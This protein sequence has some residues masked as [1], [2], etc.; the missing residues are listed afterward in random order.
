M[1]ND[2]RRT[3]PAAAGPSL[4]ALTAAALALPGLAQAQVETDLLYSRYEEVDL[5]GSREANGQD[6]ER[7]EIDTYL[8]RLA[9]PLG[10]Q[11]FVA[12]VTY[13]TL[14]GASPWY[15]QPRQPGVDDTPV[16]V[17]SGA[18]IREQ[19]T[20]VQLSWALPLA[21][22]DWGVTL[23]YSTEDDYRA[24]S[25][26]IEFEYTPQGVAHTISGGIG[27]SYDKIEPERGA[28]SPDVIAEADKDSLSAF[29]GVSWV[30]NAKTVLQTAISY[31]LHDGF[32]SDPYKRAYV[33][34]GP[35]LVADSRPGEREQF[36]VSARLRRYL[37]G[38][39]AALHADYRF[40][41][42]DWDIE[43]H[44]LELAWHQMLAESWRLTPSLRWYSQSQASFYAPYYQ[45]L[46]SDG[47]ASSDYR[48]SPYGAVA[49][50]IDLRKA[51]PG[52]WEIGGGAEWYEAD[53]SYAIDTVEVE[54]PGL[55]E[56]LI[57]NLRLGKRF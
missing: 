56:F 45:S 2:E 8:F 35:T 4:S 44:T 21:G 27:Y 51:L 10:D 28:S 34:D 41:R 22:I 53:G 49:V 11:A 20:D 39:G 18:S 12:N 40:Y 7:Y 14:S 33:A 5:P 31:G 54:N 36:T 52:D 19:R 57:L 24:T 17:M 1:K 26:G 29:A 16:Q 23:G 38:I 47:L 3:R 43:A 25:G 32:L 6:S 15:V 55:V 42:D 48:L 50:R 13:E 9:A 30:L 37:S 46:R